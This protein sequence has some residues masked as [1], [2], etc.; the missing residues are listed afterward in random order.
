MH[1]NCIVPIVDGKP[2]INA[3]GT[4][5]TECNVN[6]SMIDLTDEE[7]QRVIFKSAAIIIGD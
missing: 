2:L 3:V 1:V 6:L 5:E 7:L 4:D